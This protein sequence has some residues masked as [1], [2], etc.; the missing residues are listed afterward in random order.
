LVIEDPNIEGKAKR[1]ELSLAAAA[2]S[3][4]ASCCLCAGDLL[5]VSPPIVRD[6][7]GDFKE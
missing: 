2:A 3:S 7:R 1:E 4:L 5:L 6:K